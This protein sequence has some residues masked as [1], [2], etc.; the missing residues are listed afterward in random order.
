MAMA[1]R[2]IVFAGLLAAMFG[3]PARGDEAGKGPWE[4]IRDED[5]IAVQRRKVEGSNLAEFQ[6]RGLVHAPLARVLAVLI[7]ADRRT[8]W[9][10]KC[11]GSAL[12]EQVDD[13]HQLTWNKTKGSPASDRD[14][15]LRAEMAFD[16]SD[17]KVA[18]TF[19]STEDPRRPPTKDAVRMPFLRGHWHLWP[20]GPGDTF[21]EYQV[22]ANPGGW[23][24]AW[25]A[26]LV[27]KKL[28][29]NTLRGLREQVVRRQYPELEAKL[30]AMPEWPT[31]FPSATASAAPTSVAAP[32][33]AH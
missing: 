8:E 11:I 31:V 12:L 19:T 24:P 23:L 5:G 20:Q 15:V 6:G 10:H 14:V 2:T 27:S 1:T 17:K 21:V 30:A 18:I 7:D 33:P 22:H 28:P 13:H 3:A 32:A 25:L 9:M 4:K 26:N 16:A 29:L